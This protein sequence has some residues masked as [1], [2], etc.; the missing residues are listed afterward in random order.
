MK[1][2]L[3]RMPRYWSFLWL[4]FVLFPARGALADIH[5]VYGIAFYV[6]ELQKVD[7]SNTQVSLFGESKILRSDGVDEFVVST[8]FRREDAPSRFPPEDLTD[9]VHE[10][11]KDDRLKLALQGL[12]LLFRMPVFTGEEAEILYQRFSED[13]TEKER[14]GLRSLLTEYLASG[15]S[16]NEFYWRMMLIQGQSNPPWLDVSIDALSEDERNRFGNML[17]QEFARLLSLNLMERSR[18]L[19]S[20]SQQI[21]PS[22]DPVA[23]DLRTAL[24]QATRLQSVSDSAQL[25]K[26]LNRLGQRPALY[27]ALQELVAERSVRLAREHLEKGDPAAALEALTHLEEQQFSSEVYDVLS[28]SLNA[29]TRKGAALPGGFQLQVLLERSAHNDR[30]VASEYKH[31]LMQRMEALRSQGPYAVETVRRRLF[32]LD[33]LS[34]EE[35][36]SILFE[37][38]LSWHEGGR[39]SRAQQSLAQMTRRLETNEILKLLWSGYYFPTWLLMTIMG[40][41]A[42]VLVLL[43]FGERLFRQRRPGEPESSGAEEGEDGQP[44]FISMR[45]PLDP[46]VQEYRE[47]LSFFGL[48]LEAEL[49]EIKAEFRKR[50]KSVHPDLHR[51]ELE[52]SREFIELTESYERLIDIRKSFGLDV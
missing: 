41:L 45:N 5:Q 11:L 51:E 32:G 39:R 9:F 35:K 46:R 17:I 10:A 8:Y 23:I 7:A 18:A 1:Q 37:E 47:L 13:L 20:F 52:E 49:S 33:I 16:R 44:I 3:R 24:R 21:F 6:E 27:L 34:E 38:A 50:I 22:D 14:Q 25:K 15:L 48:P 43:V 36:N 40:F 42:A 29:V 28:N 30:R 31:Y 2:Q 12:K 19:A 4:L 26:M